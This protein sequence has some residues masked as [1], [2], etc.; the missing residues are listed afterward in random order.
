MCLVVFVFGHFGQVGR[1]HLAVAA[2][3]PAAVRLDGL[4]AGQL[5]VDAFDRLEVLLLLLVRNPRHV[6][7]GVLVG[8]QSSVDYWKQ[9]SRDKQG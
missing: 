8:K 2:V 1:G 4:E 9:K 3:I 7:G 5:A 6:R